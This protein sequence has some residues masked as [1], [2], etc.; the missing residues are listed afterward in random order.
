MSAPNSSPPGGAANQKTPKLKSEDALPNAI[1]RC[2]S[3]TLIKTGSCVGVGGILS[4][5]LFKRR[6]WP[7]TLAFG[8]GLGMGVSNCENNLNTALPK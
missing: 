3:D 1:D 2:I 8:I 5:L 6:L 4:L 7:V